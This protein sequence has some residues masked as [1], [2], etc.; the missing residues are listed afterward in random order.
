MRHLIRNV[1]RPLRAAVA[2]GLPLVIL[3]T[4]NATLRGQE[5]IAS[6]K[7]RV[8][9]A[10]GN[11]LA[12]VAVTAQS[13]ALVGALTTHTTGNGEYRF[14]A[15]PAGSYVLTFARTGLVPVKSIMRLTL[16]EAATVSVVMRSQAGEE[17]AVTVIGDRQVF[18][19][20]WSTSVVS[21]NAALDQL[22]V[23]GTIR[24]ISGLSADLAAARPEGALFLID[25]M[26]LRYGW[27]PTPYGS[28][29][30]PGRETLTDL[31]VTPGRLPAGY[32][33]LEN[34]A[35]EAQTARGANGLSGAFR[36]IFDG[37]DMNADLLREARATSSYGKSAEYTLGGGL[38][39]NHVWFFVSG[40]NLRESVD[41]RTILTD[42]AFETSTREDVGLGKLTV[43]PSA[44]HRFE[45]QWLGA[46]QRATDATPFGASLVMDADALGERT[47]ENRALSGAYTGKLNRRLDFSARYTDERGSTAWSG[48]F[49]ASRVPLFDQQTGASWWAAPVCAGCDP[50]TVTHQ[51]LR[52][53][54]DLAL[55]A[56]SVTFGYDIA[57]SELTPELD[58]ASDRFAVWAT[59]STASS[60][61]VFPVFEAGS[62]WIVWTPSIDRFA[63]VRREAFFISDHWM[64]ASRLSIDIGARLDRND[65]T[66]TQAERSVLS[67]SGISPR[68]VVNWRLSEA[69]SWTL[70]AGFARYTSDAFDRITDDAFGTGVRAF[71]YQGAPINSSSPT[72]PTAT[73]VSQL[74]TWFNAAGGTNMRPILALD[75]PSAGET[76]SPPRT[77]EYSFGISRMFGQDGDARFDVTRRTFADEARPEFERTY[78]GFSFRSGYRLGH[79]AHIEARYQVS[80]LSGNTGEPANAGVLMRRAELYYPE[81][82]ET[83]WRLPGGHLPEDAKHRLR[84]W[85]HSEIM[86]NDKLGLLLVTAVYSRE[87]G[88]PYGAAGLVTVDPFVANPGYATPPTAMLYNFTAPD[89]FRTPAMGRTDIGLNYRRRFPGTVH[90]ELL[91][92]FNVLN[93]MNSTVEWHPEQLVRVQT[94]FT[95]PALQRFNPFSETPVEGVHWTTDPAIATQ[96]TTLPRTYRFTLGIRF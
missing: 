40:R 59:R 4:L 34:G 30:G 35:F 62:T 82:F 87:S 77:D 33:R 70:T 67:E 37:A 28:F 89:E 50:R 94:A 61:V 57:R 92:A 7:G 8:T 19:P 11:G 63:R 32:G 80:N 29:A 95:N 71:G 69:A 55:G 79:W 49:G 15:L 26:P 27:Q 18:P 5:T 86:A 12:D 20:S 23:T 21:R 54:G 91:M 13:A 75:T 45:F 66:V 44:G 78:T 43:A 76:V 2:C 48:P 51:T 52:L 22:P 1:N 85:A 31:T 47:L 83:V 24:T 6:I 64:P 60:G 39:R 53:T 14:V 10:S 81:Y 96:L 68:L 16:A 93:V 9:D 46:Q 73:A 65:G 36:A 17:G 41:S 84:L 74:F 3:L 25:G 38:I 42:A 88:R 90:G 72:V 58:P 56:H